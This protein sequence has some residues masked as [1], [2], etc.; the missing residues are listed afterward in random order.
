MYFEGKKFENLINFR[1]LVAAGSDEDEETQKNRYQILMSA[2]RESALERGDIFSIK[3]FSTN[4]ENKKETFNE[5]LVSKTDLQDEIVE[6]SSEDT[7]DNDETKPV[8]KKQ[9]KF[10]MY[11]E[12]KKRIKAE[13]KKKELEQRKER[14]RQ[15]DLENKVKRIF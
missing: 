5:N 12:R 10:Q 11:L 3:Q 8:K 15:N 9:T 2:A 7:D 4:E 6:D 14:K 13:R 1:S